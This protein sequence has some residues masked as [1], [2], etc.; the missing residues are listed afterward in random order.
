MNQDQV[1]VKA[2]IIIIIIIT[3]AQQVNSV[4]IY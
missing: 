4:S 1:C 2:F 3:Q